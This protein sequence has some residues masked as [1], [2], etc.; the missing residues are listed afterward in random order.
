MGKKNGAANGRAGR[1]SSSCSYLP[2]AFVGEDSVGAY[3]LTVDRAGNQ[4][5]ALD[6]AVF[7]VRDGNAIDFQCAPDRA[8]VVGFGFD[9]ICQSAQLRTLRSDQVALRQDDVVHG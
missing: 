2:S 1:A 7:S 3:D 4:G 5:L 8:F 9:E 6:L